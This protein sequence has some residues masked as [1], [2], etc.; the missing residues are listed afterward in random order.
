VSDVRLI[1]DPPLPGPWNMAVDELLLA[2][3]IE[4]DV[5]TLRFYQ[6]SEPTLSLGYFQHYDERAQ[7][8]ASRAC[9]IIR[10]QSGGGA[11]LHDRELTYSLALPGSHPLARQTGDL[12][13]S[14]HQAFITVLT[15]ARS[16]DMPPSTLRTR[17]E[18]TEPLPA[19]EPFL[20][21][22]RRSPGD[23]I[24]VPG[25]PAPATSPQVIAPVGPPGAGWKVL[26]SAQRR[27]RGAILQHGSLLLEMSP[28]APELPGLRDLNALKLGT[29]TLIMAV[30]TQL[31]TELD[32]RL[33]SY[34]ISASLESRA[35][36]L[37][38]TKYSAAVWTKRR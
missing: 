2:D 20:C 33:I 9:T 7:H 18:P 14:V 32:L 19:T 38:N 16:A 28:A 4:N 5:A 21:F 31:S 30:C 36:D 13:S 26:G 8:V 27:H 37:S 35:A 22:Q 15:A 34:E 1:V 17:G 6:W 24:L 23:V 12:Y 25:R 11:I 3:A 10:R 29:D